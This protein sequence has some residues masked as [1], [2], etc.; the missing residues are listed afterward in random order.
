MFHDIPEAIR[1][2]M[3]QLEALDAEQRR[4]GL[5]AIQRLCA[6][7]PDTGRFLALMASCSP[8]GDLVEVG[9]AGG[10]STL[11]LAL[12]SMKSVRKLITIELREHKA[13]W[14]R[15]TFAA[16]GASSKIDL[17]LGDAIDH[18]PKIHNV[19]F[20]FLDAIEHSHIDFYELAMPNLVSGG[21]VV[22]DNVISNREDCAPFVAHVMA[23]PRVDAMVVPIGKGELLCR[24]R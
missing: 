4:Q 5:P 16:A 13:E 14:A 2:R 1:A 24:K 22:A 9:T 19:A 17:I 12:A 21:L 7:T 11:W 8:P 3:Q 6:I 18:L 15:E 23:D 10:Y 20:L